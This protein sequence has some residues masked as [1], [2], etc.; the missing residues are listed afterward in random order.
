MLWG[1][2]V[3]MLSTPI[4]VVIKILCEKLDSTQWL[5]ALLAGRVDR[6]RA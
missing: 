6:L 5:A 1:I 3:M 4:L 2:V